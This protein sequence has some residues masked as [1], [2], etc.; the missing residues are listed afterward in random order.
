MQISTQKI[1]NRKFYAD[2][3]IK[4]Q[5]KYQMRISTRNTKQKLNANF[6]TKSQTKYQ[7]QISTQNIK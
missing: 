2:F 3:R 6:C 5:P 1:S 7:M 4:F